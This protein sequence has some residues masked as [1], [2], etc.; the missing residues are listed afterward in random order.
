VMQELLAGFRFVGQSRVLLMVVVLT[1]IAMLGAGA[2]NALDIVFV[3]Q[4]LHVSTALYGPLTA[5]A[6]VG[7]LIGAIVGGLIARKVTP[8]Q[9]LTGSVF[10]LGAGLVVYAFQTNFTLAIAIILIASAPQ[11]AIDIGFT[12]L[13]LAVTPQTLM[14]RVQSVIETGMYGMSVISAA[15]AGYLAQF[16][17][18][19]IIYAVSGLL[20]AAAGVFGWF[21]IPEPG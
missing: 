6:G 7:T 21:A 1:L 4:R 19:Y 18:V 12:P 17:P 13:M 20:I 9:I 5:A 14:G 11:G 16:M 15:L 8:R 10:L 3:S 2:L